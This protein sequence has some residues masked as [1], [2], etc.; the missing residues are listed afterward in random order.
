MAIEDAVVLARCLRDI[1]L[2]EDA[3]VAYE[4]IRRDRVEK[5]VAT[6]RRNGSGKAAGPL[7]AIIRDAVMPSVVRK[8]ATEE[9]LAWMTDY[10]IDWAEPVRR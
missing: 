6:G 5:V 2:I 10:R 4:R 9:A 8:F 7:G 3:F 1:P